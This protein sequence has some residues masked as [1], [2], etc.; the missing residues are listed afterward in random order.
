MQTR[1]GMF[2]DSFHWG[3]INFCKSYEKF[4][5]S[6][7]LLSRTVLQMND[8]IKIRNFKKGDMQTILDIEYQC[9]SDPYPLSLLNRL[10]ETYPDGF[11][12]AELNG[13]VVGYII[14]AVRW[15]GYGHILAIAV[16]IEHRKMGVGTALALNMLERFRSKGVK[17]VRLEVRKSNMTARNFYLKLGFKER[18]EIP[19]YYEDGESAIVM[20]YDL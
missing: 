18:E 3:S 10:Y 12:V 6:I 17:T 4:K 13:K 15:G 8:M 7:V 1:S 19:Y 5:S 14:G 11:L 2:L 9:F 20:I 16:D